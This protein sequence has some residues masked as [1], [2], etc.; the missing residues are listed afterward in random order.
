GGKELGQ[1]AAVLHPP[2]PLFN[3]H[4]D[5]CSL[6]LAGDH[7]RPLGQRPVDHLA[8]VGLGVRDGPFP[9]LC[10]G[11]TSHGDHYGHRRLGT[12]IVTTTPKTT[13]YETRLS[14][15]AYAAATTLL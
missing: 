7:L 10:G 3:G 9:A 6:S 2:L 14:G 8:E 13:T 15:L 12:Q 1:G 11:L 4:D 5:H